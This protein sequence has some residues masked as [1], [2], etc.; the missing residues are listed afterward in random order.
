MDKFIKSVI[1]FLQEYDFD[2]I[3]LDWE[4]PVADDRGGRDEDYAN[5]VTLS[6]RL[7]KALKTTSRS[8]YSITLPA[9]FWYLQHFDIKGLEPH[10]DFFNM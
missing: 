5:F 2:G 6:K 1:K 7:K 10:V 4:Y 8:G 3:D 9:S